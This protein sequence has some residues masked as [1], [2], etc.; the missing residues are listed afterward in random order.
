MLGW[1]LILVSLVVSALI[2]GVVSLIY[3]VIKLITGKYHAFMA[4]PYGPFLVLGAVILIY[5]RDA[6]LKLIGG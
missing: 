3:I 2:G 5:F 6:V 1:P 4:L